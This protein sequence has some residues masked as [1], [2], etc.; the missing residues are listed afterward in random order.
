MGDSL[1]ANADRLLRDVQRIH[2]RMTRELDSVGRATDEPEV[3]ASRSRPSA[4]DEAESS[5]SPSG[6]VL[7][8]PEFLPGH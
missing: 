6:E 3:T 1:K 5:L 8:V 4:A 2:S 7:D